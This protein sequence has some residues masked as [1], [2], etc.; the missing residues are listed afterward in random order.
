M[1]FRLETFGE[2]R[3]TNPAGEA[4]AFPAKGLVALC[5]L[6]DQP[7]RDFPRAAL[8]RFLWDGRETADAATNL[9]KLI[10]RIQMRQSELGAEFLSFTPTSVRVLR[11]AFGSD[12]DEIRDGGLEPLANLRKLLA[13]FRRDFLTGIDEQSP[14]LRKWIDMQRDRHMALLIDGLK[15][16]LPEAH[17]HENISLIK[18]AALRIFQSVPDDETVRRILLDAYESEGH[19]DGARQAF[20]GRAVAPANKPDNSDLPA[21]REV[22]KIFRSEP[23]TVPAV[24]E[25]EEA[26]FLRS[27]VLPR[28]ALLPPLDIGIEPATLPL[29]QALIEDVTIGL[30]ALNTVSVVAPYTAEQISRDSDKPNMIARHTISYVL[31]TRINDHGNGRALFVQLIHV[32]N[33]E[34]IWAER[35]SLDKYDLITHRRE[36]AQHISRE[37]AGQV[38]RNES[39]RQYFESSPAAYHS[40]LVG[41]RDLKRFSLPD[42]RR[43]RKAFREALQHNAHFAPAMSGLS[44]TFFVE[45]LLTARGDTAL[46]KASEDFANQAIVIDNSLPTGF[47]ELGVAK[48]YLGDIDESVVALKLAEELSPHYADVIES[49]ADALIHASRPA[50]ALAKVERAIALNPL[51]PDE[52]LWTSAG[53]NFSL[54]RYSEALDEIAKMHNRTPVDRLSAACFAMMG[55]TKNAKLFARKARETYPDFNIDKWLSIVPFKEQWQ[56]DL[57]REALSRA[58][59]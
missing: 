49:Y 18:E 30:C 47:R 46:L 51:C 27:A 33:D 29:T 59:F 8:A 17:S 3:L 2:L 4:V 38:R 28:L 37:L 23:A 12:L 19:L 53:A 31:D 43:A 52:Y 40:Y 50:D 1:T 24:P 7:D 48:L 44:R 45:W 55:D 35:F 5:Y 42:I 25:R 58:G 14:A 54:Q 11:D 20:E 41:Q 39:V 13:I 22:M 6:L 36:I 21:L 9:R 16:A 56:K 32:A 26:G 10:S 57:Y 34:V 15:R